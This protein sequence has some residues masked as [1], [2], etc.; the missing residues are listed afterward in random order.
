MTGFKTFPPRLAGA[1]AAAPRLPRG[2]AGLGGQPAGARGHPQVQ[3]RAQAVPRLSGAVLGTLPLG[4]V[5]YPRRVAR[6][7][8]PRPF[9]TDFQTDPFFISIH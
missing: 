4:Q 1:L 8:G 6:C 5:R 9:S 2:S 7:T 3:H